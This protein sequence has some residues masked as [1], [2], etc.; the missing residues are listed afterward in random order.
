MSTTRAAEFIVAI[1]S[2]SARAAAFDRACSLGSTPIRMIHPS[3]V[4]LAGAEV[5]PGS[6]VCAGAVVGVD[7]RLGADVIV[8]TMAS[9]DHDAVIGDHAFV[10][11]GVHLAGRVGIGAGTHVGIGATII[12][13]VRIGPESTV[14]AGAVVIADV[15][16]GTRVAGVPARYHGPT[17]GTGEPMTAHPGSAQRAVPMARPNLS[18]LEREL[19]ADVLSGDR[20]RWDRYRAVRGRDRH[21]RRPA[22]RGRLHQ[23]HRRPPHGRPGARDRPGRRGDHDA[24]QLRRVGELPP[25]RAA[26]PRASSTS[27]RTRLGLDPD[28]VEAAVAPRT[29]AVLP[30]HVFGQSVP[31]RGDRGDRAASAGWAMH[32]GRLRGASGSSIDGRRSARFGDASV[33]AFYPNKQIT[34][35]EGGVV[36]TDD[37]ALAEM[38]RSLRNQGRDERRDLASARAARLQLPARRDVGR[39][40]R[41]PA[42]AASPSCGPVATG[43]RAAYDRALGGLRLGRPARA[44]VPASRRRLVR[45]RRPAGSRDRPRPRDRRPRRPRHPGASLLQPAPPPAVLP[46]AFGFRRGDFPVTERVAR[47]TLA[48]PF[49]SHLGDADV[50]RVIDGLVDAVGDQAAA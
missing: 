48:L 9:V 45:L 19:V 37:D 15:P 42:R 44:P 32:R 14:A 49:F 23:R 20:S 4:L 50:D 46:R 39:R 10:A 26:R 22:T 29:R 41:R 43:S 33:F 16:A 2:N 31:D 25:V 11:P 6:Q 7:A 28:R 1:G 38:L 30:V 27:R 47:S 40:R 24:V 21:H 17:T 18:D 8:N 36:V 34:T 13:G 5:G 12:E 3:A 35:G